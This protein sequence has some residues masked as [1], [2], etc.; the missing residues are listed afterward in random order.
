MCGYQE[1]MLLGNCQKCSMHHYQVL[2]SNCCANYGWW[3]PTVKFTTSYQ[4]CMGEGCF[5]I[6][7]N[8]LFSATA[9]EY[10]RKGSQR[11]FTCT[12]D[13][14]LSA[15]GSDAPIAS[16]GTIYRLIMTGISQAFRLRIWTVCFK[17]H[18]RDSVTNDSFNG[19]RQYARCQVMHNCFGCT[20]ID[21]H[22]QYA[23]WSTSESLGYSG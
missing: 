6:R 8:C 7:N 12:Q 4:G 5:Y 10:F 1:G 11:D 13:N 15:I 19:L 14:R 2:V 23:M 18:W 17:R 21:R 9:M 20:W 16:I 3:L 22:G